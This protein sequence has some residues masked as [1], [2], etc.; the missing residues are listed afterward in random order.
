MQM[1][2]FFHSF[3]FSLSSVQFD[4]HIFIRKKQFNSFNCSKCRAKTICFANV[5]HN[6]RQNITI[7]IFV[8]VCKVCQLDVCIH[9]SV[10]C[11]TKKDSKKLEIFSSES[12]FL[13]FSFISLPAIS[14]EK[15]KRCWCLHFR[16]LVVY[17]DFCSGFCAFLLHLIIGLRNG[18]VKIRMNIDQNTGEHEHWAQCTVGKSHSES[19][20]IEVL[21]QPHC[22]RHSPS[23]FPVSKIELFN[24]W[25]EV[26]YFLQQIKCHRSMEM[27][28]PY[29]CHRWIKMWF[30]HST[31]EWF[32]TAIYGL[33][34]C[35]RTIDDNGMDCRVFFRFSFVVQMRRRN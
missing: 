29:Y 27:H 2:H 20:S 30:H 23:I 24:L 17:L 31:F 28:L 8:R 6:I 18:S 34:R 15:K 25:I 13:L 4:T 12:F 35:L 19:S 10:F 22:L 26:V 5:F 7:C 33:M 3:F 9:Y 21:H 16:I 11:A 32:V 1:I 14:T